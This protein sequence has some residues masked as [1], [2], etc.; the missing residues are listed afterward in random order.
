MNQW[1]GMMNWPLDPTYQCVVCGHGPGERPGT[2]LIT[3]YILGAPLEWGIVN[4]HCRCTRCH[5]EYTLR[6]GDTVL[7]MPKSTLRDEYLKPAK[8]AWEQWHE[9]IDDLSSK[10]WAEAFAAVGAA[11]PVP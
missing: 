4:G 11:Y 3:M 9:P 6:D 10:Q 8:W 5:A 2:E 7:T 1:G